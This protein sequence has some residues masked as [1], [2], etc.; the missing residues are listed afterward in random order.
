M[1]SDGADVDGLDFD[2]TCTDPTG[3]LIYPG[4]TYVDCPDGRALRNEYG[5]GPIGGRWHT[6]GQPC[7]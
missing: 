4:A 7:P 1:F 3:A 6:E 2:K 5:W